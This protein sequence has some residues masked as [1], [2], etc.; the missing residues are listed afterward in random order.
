MPA[1]PGDP[2]AAQRQAAAAEATALF[3]LPD[4]RVNHYAQQVRNRMLAD[5]LYLATWRVLP[6][7]AQRVCERYG[8]DQRG[9]QCARC[10]AVQAR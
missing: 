4:G 9:M 3:R 8:H 1:Q 7:A 2:Y 5:L 6:D 10:G